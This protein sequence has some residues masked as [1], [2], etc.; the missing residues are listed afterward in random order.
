[1]TVENNNLPDRRWSDEDRCQYAGRNGVA[2]AR[3]NGR[4]VSK[5]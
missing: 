4:T 2:Y 3:A 1:M 5:R